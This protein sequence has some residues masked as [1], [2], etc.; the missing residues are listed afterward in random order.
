V[1]VLIRPYTPLDRPALEFMFGR[2]SAESRYLRFFSA[3]RALTA[4]D[5]ARLT[6]V[7][8]WHHEALLAFSPWPRAPIGVARYV[9][10]ELFDVAEIAVAVVDEWQ[11]QGVGTALVAALRERAAAAG[12][13]RFTYTLLPE[14]R[15]ARALAHHASSAGISAVALRH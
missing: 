12:I 8:H 6:A 4:A 11:R 14:N 7:D 5:L 9:R 1:D 3:K 13:R 2:L 15:G 10:A